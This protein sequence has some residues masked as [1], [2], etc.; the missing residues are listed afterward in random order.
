[1]KLPLSR[2]AEFTSASVRFAAE[3]GVEGPAALAQ[4]C[5]L[6]EGY[7]IDSRTIQ[8]GQVF[9]AV[10]GERFDGHNFVET[11][12]NNGA[13]ASVIAKEHLSRF[14]H[15]KN[16]KLLIVDNTLT[17]LQA[18]GAAVRR[19]WAKP[20]VAVTGSAGKTTTKE[21][22]AHL[23]SKR[24]RVMKSEGNLNNHFGLPLQLL[25]LEP[26]HDI[27]VMELGMSHLGE[28]AALARLARPDTG[29]VT[30]VAPVH[31]E[32]FTS[33]AEIARAKFELIESLP[34][35]GTAILNADD[36]YVSQFGREFHG[37]VV[38]FGITHPADVRAE[39]IRQLGDEG[40]SFTMVVDGIRE[41]VKL[42]LLGSHNVVNA[43][44]AAAAALQYGLSPSEV[45]QAISELQP[46]EKR[47]ELFKLAGS[48][49]AIINDCYNSN[50]I[51]LKAMVETLAQLPANR[52]IVVAGEMLELGRTA[53]NMHRD[54]GSYIAGKADIL[55]GVSGL[56]A[57][58]VQGARAG[59]IEAKFFATPEAAGEALAAEVRSGDAILFKASRGVRLERALDT[60]QTQF[61][62]AAQKH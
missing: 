60:L 32:F 27:A 4:A 58:M 10:K 39:N 41:P 26:Q 44:A 13:V 49:I 53:E 54:C 48:D 18:L 57:D 5:S 56:A 51:A 35:R 15:L 2:V 40:S 37:K 16:K 61:R 23:L 29:V 6:A 8:P 52:H 47:G 7:S 11:A 17:A 55:F 38:T 33:I 62:S 22:I 30:C 28:I 36:E 34:V 59:G 19:L 45:A 12:F 25:R 3:G 43:L 50:P 42:P 14:A 21:A 9:F 46:G 1:M 31:L 20:L 24:M